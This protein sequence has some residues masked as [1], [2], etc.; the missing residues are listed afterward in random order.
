MKYRLT[1]TTENTD[2]S[3]KHRAS[4]SDTEEETENKTKN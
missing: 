1:Q 3:L 2:L 4:E